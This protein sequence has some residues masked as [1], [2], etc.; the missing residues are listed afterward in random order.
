MRFSSVQFAEFYEGSALAA[1]N[2]RFS[3]RTAGPDI[4][5]KKQPAADNVG[6]EL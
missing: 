5:S 4:A 1:L 2:C 6:G 3:T